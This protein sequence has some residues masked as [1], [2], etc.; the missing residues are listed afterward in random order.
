MNLVF[1]FVRNYIKISNYVLY[2][3][4][5]RIAIRIDARITFLSILF[6]LAIVEFIWVLM[7]FVSAKILLMVSNRKSYKWPVLKLLSRE[8]VVIIQTIILF[9]IIQTS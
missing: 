1:N 3:Y 4:Y 2:F 8:N 9:K 5:S 7:Q 6:V